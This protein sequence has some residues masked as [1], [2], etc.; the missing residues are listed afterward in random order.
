MP[1]SG[2]GGQRL[3]VFHG[4]YYDFDDFIIDLNHVGS[5]ILACEFCGDDCRNHFSYGVSFGHLY[6]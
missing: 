4:E 2:D 6:Q 5:E 3:P 1:A